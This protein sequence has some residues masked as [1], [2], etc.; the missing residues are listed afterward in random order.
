MARCEQDHGV[1]DQQTLHHLPRHEEA[2]WEDLPALG[3]HHPC[4]QEHQDEHHQQ[5][6]HHIKDSAAALGN[7]PAH[8]DRM[9]CIL[10][11]IFL[12]QDCRLLCLLVSWLDS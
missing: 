10:S 2:E 11:Y 6:T 3:P 7:Q 5:C 1:R 12:L 4:V 8:T 9:V